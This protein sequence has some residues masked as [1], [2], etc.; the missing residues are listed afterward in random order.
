MPLYCVARSACGW[1]LSDKEH[2]LEVMACAPQAGCLDR[3]CDHWVEA[4]KRLEL[5]IKLGGSMLAACLAPSLLSH[6]WR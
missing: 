4:L 3:N 6:G 2:E 5:S 1:L